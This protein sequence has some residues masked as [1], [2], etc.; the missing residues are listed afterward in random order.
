MRIKSYTE[1][2]FSKYEP[3]SRNELA[4]WRRGEPDYRIS[5]SLF[6][7]NFNKDIQF[8]YNAAAIDFFVRYFLKISTREENPAYAEYGFPDEFLTDAYVRDAVH[9]QLKHAKRYWNFSKN[10]NKKKDMLTRIEKNSR[11]YTVFTSMK[12]DSPDF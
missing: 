12:P 10:P 4:L 2:G 1:K 5:Q 3:L 8:D 6:R 11:K 7:Y 9:I